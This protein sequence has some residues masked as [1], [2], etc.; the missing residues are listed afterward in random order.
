VGIVKHEDIFLALLDERQKILFRHEQL[1]S[2]ADD[3][4]NFLAKGL[5]G[6]RIVNN[7]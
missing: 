2:L 4:L 6:V 1:G 5:A 7:E 3:P